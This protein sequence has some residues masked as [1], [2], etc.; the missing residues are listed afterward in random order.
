[1]GPAERRLSLASTTSAVLS[2]SLSQQAAVS[3]R[4]SVEAAAAAPP[5]PTPRP[6]AQFSKV[7]AEQE[8]NSQP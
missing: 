8:E 6:S 2:V 4:S 7:Q 3:A 5:P 1:M